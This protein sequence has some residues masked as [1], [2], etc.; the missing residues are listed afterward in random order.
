MMKR[1]IEEG[2]SVPPELTMEIL[3]KAMVQSGNDKFLLDGFPR[4]EEI[5]AAFEAAVSSSIWVYCL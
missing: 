1:M 2:E 3:M 5:R 4:D